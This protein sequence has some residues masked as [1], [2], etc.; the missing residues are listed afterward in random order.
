MKNKYDIIIA[1]SGISGM[2]LAHYCAQHGMK[3]LVIEKNKTLGG[4]FTT[5]YSGDFWLEMGAH[6]MY[7]S[8]GKLID[9]IEGCGLGNNI[10]KRKKVPYKVYKNGRIQSVISQ[11]NIFELLFS[12]PSLFKTK[13][14]NQTVESYYS[15]ILGKNNYRKFFQYMFNAVPSQPTNDFP[16]NI[17]FKKRPRRKD[18]LKS[19]TLE[20][21]IRSIIEAITDN[22]NIDTKVDLHVKS[23]VRMGDSYLVNTEN[24]QSFESSY[25]GM[26]TPVNIT[27]NLVEKLNPEISKQLEKIEN[28]SADSAGIIIRKENIA[29]KEV[30]GIIGMNMD[31][32][33]VVSRDVVE[34]P[35]IRGFVFHFKPGKLNNKEKINYICKVLNI[36]EDNIL[37]T[38]YAKNIVP[39]YRP[40]HESIVAK[41]DKLLATEKIFMTGNYFTG[42]AIEDCVKRSFLEN[43]RL[44]KLRK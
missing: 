36:S 44:Q 18:I 34:H 38:F 22:T 16:A 43:E 39:S 15:K 6:T 4:S 26:A 5:E 42:M 9:I 37:H 23:V 20:R 25:I 24:N 7:N 14:D 21:G 27:G 1:G 35:D 31:F 17:L 8:Y 30:A 10:K 29:L 19:Y 2:S 3:V 13:K 40:G 41:I 32:Y 11:F 28:T 12:L 33:S